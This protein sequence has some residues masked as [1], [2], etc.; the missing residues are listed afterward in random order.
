MFIPI[1]LFSLLFPSFTFQKFVVIG[2]VSDTTGRSV[3]YV[4]VLA[5]DE[6]F[7]PIRTIFVDASGQFFVRGLSPGR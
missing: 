1:L 2:R 5:I 6:N 4:R 7:Q 3:P